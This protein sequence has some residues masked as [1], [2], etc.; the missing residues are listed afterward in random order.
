MNR[1][2]TEETDESFPFNQEIARREPTS[3]GMTQLLESAALDWQDK[4]Q[5]QKLT[6]D[7]ANLKCVQALRA[8]QEGDRIANP[9]GSEL[10]RFMSHNAADIPLANSSMGELNLVR[11]AVQTCQDDNNS[12]NCAYSSQESNEPAF[13]KRKL[14]CLRTNTNPLSNE[15][16]DERVALPITSGRSPAHINNYLSAGMISREDREDGKGEDGNIQLGTSLPMSSVTSSVR[17]GNEPSQDALSIASNSVGNPSNRKNGL[18]KHCK[19]ISDNPQKPKRR[20][21]MKIRAESYSD[22]SLVEVDSKQNDGDDSMASMADDDTVTS[23]LN[24]GLRGPW[25][26]IYAKV[27]LFVR[28]APRNLSNSDVMICHAN[29]DFFVNFR[30]DKSG[31]LPIPLKSLFGHGTSRLVLH[32]LHMALVA[33]KQ[34]HEFINLYRADNIPLACHVVLV[35]ITGNRSKEGGTNLFSDS[36]PRRAAMNAQYQE[37]YAILTIRSASVIGNA[38]SYG[39][40]FFGPGRIKTVPAAS[41]RPPSFTAEIDTQHQEASRSAGETTNDTESLLEYRPQQALPPQEGP[42]AS[43]EQRSVN[44]YDYAP[45]NQVSRTA[46]MQVHSQSQKHPKGQSQ[47]IARNHRQ[48]GWGRVASSRST[49]ADQPA[50]S[51]GNGSNANMYTMQ[52]L[53]QHGAI[54]LTDQGHTCE[55]SDSGEDMQDPMSNSQQQQLLRCAQLI[56]PHEQFLRHPPSLASIAQ[57][58]LRPG[59]GQQQLVQHHEG[60]DALRQHQHLW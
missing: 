45:T 6:K 35:S 11:E 50:D 47:I 60:R 55:S 31:S 8:R 9:P 42:Y 30:Y 16:D 10:C 49:D 53:T 34:V 33:G 54:A 21:T 2:Q 5:R 40:G 56:R 27:K 39:I 44:V 22:S 1:V 3:F 7:G 17:T 23:E 38:K 59:A 29:D 24:S 12:G 37:K 57:D 46:A 51:V 25:T 43:Q 28:M 32:K 48:K 14:D 13:K 52:P 19:P 26:N 20:A 58:S 15:D 4:M 18:A 41:P 36:M